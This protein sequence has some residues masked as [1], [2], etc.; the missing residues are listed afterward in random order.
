[1]I[2]KV[3]DYELL[4]YLFTFCYIIN[5]T[6]GVDKYKVSELKGGGLSWNLHCARYRKRNLYHETLQNTI[7]KVDDYKLLCYFFT[8]YYI[9]DTSVGVDKCKVSEWWWCWVSC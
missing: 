8:F 4:C 5:A 7:D 1:M 6:V 3:D 2:N 9:I